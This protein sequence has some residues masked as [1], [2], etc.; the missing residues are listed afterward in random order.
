MTRAAQT[1]AWIIILTGF[2][3]LACAGLGWQSWSD[4]PFLVC[5]ALA[6]LAATFKMKLPNLTGTLSPAFVF[7]LVAVATLSW[8]QTVIIGAVSGVVQCLWRPKARPSALQVAF[9]AATMAISAA[10]ASGLATANAAGPAV[11]LGTAAVALLVT[12]TLIVSTILCF[13]K[14]APF[15]SVWRSFQLWAVPY[16]LAGGVL[17]GIWAHADLRAGAGV[18]IL[19]AASVYVLS[20]CYRE[21]GLLIRE[22]MPG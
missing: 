6:A 16:Y 1:Y 13:V 10:V 9:N 8:S 18:I 21:F 4:A 7:L 14:E 2:A 12:N 22:I 15:H 5:L 11:L 20:V 17:A 19:A 3:V